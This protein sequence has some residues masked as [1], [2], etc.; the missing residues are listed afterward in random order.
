VY[1]WSSILDIDIE[2]RNKLHLTKI[3]LFTTRAI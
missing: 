3:S 2:F 1:F